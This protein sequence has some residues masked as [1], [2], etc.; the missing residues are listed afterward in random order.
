MASVGASTPQCSGMAMSRLKATHGIEAGTIANSAINAQTAHEVTLRY[1][2]KCRC[3]AA[4][5]VSSVAALAINKVHVVTAIRG[6][7]NFAHFAI[8]TAP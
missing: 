8:Y 4:Q 7:A 2:F 5:V 6:R 3:K 1:R